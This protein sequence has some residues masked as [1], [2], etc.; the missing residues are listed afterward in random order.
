MQES[1]LTSSGFTAHRATLADLDAVLV[2]VQDSTRRMQEKGLSQWRLYLTDA[3]EPRI[4]RRVEGAAS[5]EVYLFKRPSDDHAV[6]V[7][8]IEWTD[9]EYWGDR[10]VDDLAGYIHMLAVH[11]LARGTCLGER[12]VAWAERLVA[13]RGRP[14]ARLDCWAGSPFLPGYYERLGYARVGHVGSA[15]GSILMEKRVLA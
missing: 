15:N 1:T 3:G 7:V 10:G 14:L 2:V 8:S 13:S 5:E 9:H 4:R 12:I 6:G 11:R